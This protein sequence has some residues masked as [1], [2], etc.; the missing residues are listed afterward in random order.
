[1]TG[2][3]EPSCLSEK[4]LALIFPYGSELEKQAG[5]ESRNGPEKTEGHVGLLL[6]H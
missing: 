2:G 5:E 6:S 3:Y 1:M 4:E